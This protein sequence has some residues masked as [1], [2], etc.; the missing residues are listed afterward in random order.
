MFVHKGAILSKQSWKILYKEKSCS[1]TFRLL[2]NFNLF[3]WFHKKKKHYVYR[4]KD[5]VEYFCRKLKGFET[6]IFNYEKKDMKPLRNEEVIFCE[7]QKQ[8]H[9]CKKRFF[10]NKKDNYKHIK[11]GDHCHYTGKFRGDA[12]STCNLRY[13]VPKKFQ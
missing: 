12:H 10:R 2:V 1:W 7:N 3:V 5:C 4:W 8:C 11:V 13:N 9:I 6:E